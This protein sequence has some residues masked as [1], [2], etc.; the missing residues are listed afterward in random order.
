[1]SLAA[2][3]AIIEVGAVV[4]KTIA[5][6]SAAKAQE[7]AI[8]EKELQN[9]LA[10]NRQSIERANSVRKVLGTQIADLGARGIGP[11]SASFSAIQVDTF[12][13]FSSD[14]KAISLN[15]QFQQD[16]LEQAK[17]NARNKAIFGAVNNIFQAGEFFT[18]TAVPNVP[19]QTQKFDIY[20]NNTTNTFGPP[21]LK[22]GIF[23]DQNED[24]YGE[25]A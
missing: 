25:G 18:G 3:P 5:G 15:E 9:R 21:P 19:D 6:F 11:S 4:G 14:E 10:S 16:F 23:S 12:N 20:G 24:I 7:N 17:A 8:R 13:Q 1:M 2:L 22:R